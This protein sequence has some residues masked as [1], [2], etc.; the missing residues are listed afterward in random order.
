MNLMERNHHTKENDWREDLKSDLGIEQ[1]KYEELEEE[2]GFPIEDLDQEKEEDE[3]SVQGFLHKPYMTTVLLG[4]I[5][6]LL[7]CI[8]ILLLFMPN[9]RQSAQTGGND[10]LQQSITQYAQEQKQNDYVA[11]LSGETVAIDPVDTSEPKEETPQHTVEEETEPETAPVSVDGDKTAVVVDVE[12]EN[13]ISYSKEFIL[14]EAL[15]Y[16]ADNNQDAIWDLAHLKRYV[17]LSEELKNTDQYYYKGDV[18]SDGR[19]DGQGLAIYENNSYYYGEW[20]DGVRSGTGTWYRFYIGKINKSNAMGKY[21]AHSY[22]GSWANDLPDGQG[23]EHFDVDISKLKAHER[24]LQNVVGN[25][26][27]GLYDGE[28]YMNT[29]DYTGNVEEWSGVTEKGVFTLWRDMSAIGECA[30][31]R[32]NDDHSLCIDIDKSE[33]KN[34]GLRELLKTD[35]K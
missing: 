17:K 8:I 34:Q 33:N 18:N 25:F 1:T 10:N 13:D 31:W 16:F 5:L 24:I 12:D 28:L 19:P 9:R 27:G 3:E 30:V 4:V 11:G 21:I 29:V 7:I 35:E 26:S 20:V 14:N 2:D 22:A 15:P 6:A 23:A 32:K